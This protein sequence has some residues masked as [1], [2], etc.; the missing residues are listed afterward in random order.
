MPSPEALADSL[1]GRRVALPETRE[2][3]VLATLLERRGA[4][5]LR[6]PMVAILDT[7][8][9][10]AVRDWLN[11]FIDHPPEDFVILTGEGIRR[12][13]GFAERHGRRE[14]FVAALART[15]KI[16]RGPK[17][18]RA[19]REL[20][21]SSDLVGIAPTTEGVIQTLGESDLAGRRI[22]VQLYGEEPNLRL[23]EYLHA[24][25]AKVSCVA[26][27]VYASA[28]DAERVRDLIDHL[29]AGRVDAIAFTS[30]PQ[31]RRLAQ[32]AQDSGRTEVLSAALARV[33]VAAIGPIVA[34]DLAAAGVRVDVMPEGG[35][36]MKPLVSALV[37]ALDRRAA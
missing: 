11:A 18:G 35:F 15:R 17:P 3:D 9:V 37:A 21:L 4:Q 22:A 33:C 13:V 14:A 12:L 19:L 2:L 16:A 1:A 5:V 10:E 7:P 30:T 27:Y 31:Y 6:C 34:Q 32:V 24:R 23:R 36:Y 8:N 25:G 29:A 20:G 26:P 28:A